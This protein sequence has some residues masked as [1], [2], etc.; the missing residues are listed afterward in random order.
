MK[1]MQP[2]ILQR[3]RASNSSEQGLA[4]MSQPEAKAGKLAASTSR[5]EGNDPATQAC[6]I[7]AKSKRQREPRMAAPHKQ[8]QLLARVTSSSDKHHSST[9]EAAQAAVAI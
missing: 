6:K 9:S 3:S 5:L 7:K 1:Q 4:S 8:G 2:L